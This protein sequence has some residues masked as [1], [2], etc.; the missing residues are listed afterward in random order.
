MT[1][2]RKIPSVKEA[3]AALERIRKTISDAEETVQDAPTAKQMADAQAQLAFARRRLPQL[4]AELVE[5][6]QAER[7]QEAERDLQAAQMSFGQLQY[8][9]GAVVSAVR[10]AAEQLE[11]YETLRQEHAAAVSR[12]RASSLQAGLPEGP[13]WE[14]AD[15]PPPAGWS[16]NVL[17]ALRVLRK[18]CSF[19]LN[20][21]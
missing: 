20:S 6:E 12:A 4:E 18:E 1:T 17:Q 16:S 21:S 15:P 7:T 9:Q 14:V 19:L 2:T 5:A 13:V 8:A 11:V 10:E 3:D